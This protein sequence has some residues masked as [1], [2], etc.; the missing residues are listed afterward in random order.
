MTLVSVVSIF[1][2]VLWEDG[3]SLTTMREFLPSLPPGL[4]LLD[5]GPFI[6]SLS[7]L[8]LSKCKEDREWAWRGEK[9]KAAAMP[10]CCDR[11]SHQLAVFP[12]R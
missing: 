3:H 8:S 1:L 10:E 9:C 7:F 6:P 5:C 2:F 4:T 11:R 12:H